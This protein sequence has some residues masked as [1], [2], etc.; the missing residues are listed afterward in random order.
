MRDDYKREIDYMRI[1]LTDRCNLRC[2]YCMPDDIELV[3]MREILTL[4]EIVIICEEAAKLGIRKL[5]VTGGEPLVRRGCVELIGMLKKV[6]GIEQVTMTTNGVAL[7]DVAKKLQKNGLD[8]VNIS[9][10][11]LD[12]EKFKQITGYDKFEKV[13]RAI[14][15]CCEI[16]IRTKINVVLQRGMNEDEWEELILLAKKYPLDMRFI[17]MMPIGS[18]QEFEPIYN[19]NILEKI[20]N[21]YPQIQKDNRVHGNGPAVYYFIPGFLGAIGFINAMHGKFCSSCN[22]IRL[23]S[24]GQLKPCLCFEDFVDIKQAVRYGSRQEVARQLRLAILKKPQ[25]HNFEERAA[26]TESKKMVQIGG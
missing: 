22:R 23:T 14:K 19:E 18:G 1:S 10:D 13:M 7:L 16:G 6:S 12:R 21:K 5:K 9:L 8:A 20:K 4:E 25:Q 26:I 2:R 17:E 3:P 11:T 15:K 24:T